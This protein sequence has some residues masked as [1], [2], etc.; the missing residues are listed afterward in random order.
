MR[1]FCVTVNVALLNKNRQ[2]QANHK[3]DE[4]AG[5]SD[6]N[7]KIPRGRETQKATGQKV[8][9]C[10]QEQQRKCHEKASKNYDVAGAYGCCE[11][12]VCFEK[13]M[14]HDFKKTRVVTETVNG[15]VNMLRAQMRELRRKCE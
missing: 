13:G 12:S 10:S 2:T 4:L 5:G 6:E 11:Q 3:C 7:W 1:R 8:V 15:L 9:E 14:S